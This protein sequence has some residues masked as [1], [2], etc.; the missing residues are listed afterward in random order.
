MF[1]RLSC[2]VIC[3]HLKLKAMLKDK[4]YFFRELSSDGNISY[5]LTFHSAGLVEE[6]L[7]Y[8]SNSGKDVSVT[9][10][11]PFSGEIVSAWMSS[12]EIE[13]FEVSEYEHSS[14]KYVFDEI[15]K[16]FLN[17]I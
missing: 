6:V 9:Y 16:N 10:F 15:E 7:S 8:G 4:Y 12:D 2:T 3:V 14:L 17:E 13:L 1:P 5:G 11:H